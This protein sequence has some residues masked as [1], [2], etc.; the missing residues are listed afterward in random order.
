M[1]LGRPLFVHR[2][3]V[4][5]PAP[6]G[7]GALPAARGDLRSGQHPRALT[8]PGSLPA[9]LGATRPVHAVRSG[10]VCQ[11]GC[12]R[13]TLG[14]PGLRPDSR[15]V[16]GKLPNRGR[17][18]L[19]GVPGAAYPRRTRVAAHSLAT[20][21][22]MYSRFLRG[23][24]AH[25]TQ[26]STQAGRLDRRRGEAGDPDGGLRPRVRRH[27]DHHED[28]RRRRPRRCPRRRRRARQK[29]PAKKATTAKKAPAKKATTAKKAPAKKA[30]AATKTHRQED[31]GEED[32]GHQD[33]R[34]RTK[35][36]PGA[37]ATTTAKKTSSAAPAKK[38]AVK[39]TADSPKTAAKKVP[40]TT[41]TQN[42]AAKKSPATT[43]APEKTAPR[44]H[45]PGEAR[46]QGR[47]EPV[48]QGRAGRGARRPQRRPRPAPLRAQPRRA[49]AARPDAGRRRRRR[50]RPGRRRRRRRSSATTR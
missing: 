21:S 19:S 40:V 36:A 22:L 44:G 5:L 33:D 50:Q 49:R 6:G 37:P 8:V 41:P 3:R 46:G 1:L 30:P 13:F 7:A 47:R 25:G 43:T 35:T 26:H 32:A 23:P 31:D 28:A 39:K 24:R 11:T 48:D 9:V 42:A 27:E 10:Q 38:P 16:A 4:Y 17:G 45:G 14:L 12:P 15:M 34:G 18:W 29:A 20:R 2:C